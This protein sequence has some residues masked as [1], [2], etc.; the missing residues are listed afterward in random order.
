MT[1]CRLLSRFCLALT[2]ILTGQGSM[3]RDSLDMQ[4]GVVI[5]GDANLGLASFAPE[6]SEPR[7]ALDLD[8]AADD[9]RIDSL[10]PAVQG[11]ISLSRT[12]ITDAQGRHILL[13]SLANH[14]RT[15]AIVRLR[16]TSFLPGDRA[17]RL[18]SGTGWQSARGWR[19]E[20]RLAGRL[21][22]G[23]PAGVSTYP[24]HDP[25]YIGWE[26][27]LTLKP[28]E[29]KA[30]LAVITPPGTIGAADLGWLSAAQRAALIGWPGGKGGRPLL[31]GPPAR[32]AKWKER[33]R[34]WGAEALLEDS[35][36]QAAWLAVRF[37][38][39]APV[40][41]RNPAA[42]SE[43]R[44]IS[45]LDP[46]PLAGLPVLVKDIIDVVD[47]PTL[48]LATPM[49]RTERN[50]AAIVTRLRDAGAVIL[51]KATFDEDF[52]DYGLH[53]ATGRLRG[54]FHPDVTVTGSSG[55]SAV[56]V[57]AG[58]VPLA[59]GSDTCGSLGTPASHA[60]V[61]TLRPSVDALP[62]LGARPLNPDFDTLGP[63]LADATDLPQ[64]LT[65]LSAK[66]AVPGPPLQL[67]GLRLGVIE[68]W[69][70]DIPAADQ[71]VARQFDRAIARLRAAGV[72]LVPVALPDW[73]DARNALRAKPEPMRT[74]RAVEAWLAVRSDQRTIAELALAPYLLDED[75]AG[76]AALMLARPDP[77][78][79][80]ARD[81]ALQAVQ[82]A[83]TGPM[84]TQ[85][86]TALILPAT[87]AW[88][89]LLD[90]T[91]AGVGEP[92]MCPLSALARLPQA[93]IPLARQSGEPPL[94]AALLGLPG[95]DAM[96]GALAA[97]LAPI[98]ADGGPVRPLVPPSR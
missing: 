41:S 77:A 5:A 46:R 49:P 91:R 66:L 56:A 2:L 50:D 19:L 27:R 73:P 28:G 89:G 85:H 62:Y 71:A 65:A 78:A 21:V 12:R 38:G 96:L 14:G 9:H 25:G 76:M 63:V 94:G 74:A 16:W 87:L 45:P 58:I 26:L 17:S 40:S 64:A 82:H 95:E 61:A 6:G 86:V 75:R 42:F 39:L 51:G 44:A 67:K 18:A 84:A 57:A 43:A 7:P 72:Q 48:T 1:R 3:A 79:S 92:A 13:D 53:R 98:L 55:G 11:D 69:P 29:R 8:L 47:M 33:R 90:V 36:A 68:P 81:A 80:R 97:Q 35:L 83:L 10:R 23:W 20:T 32:L 34:Q 59:I 93:T 88:P 24:G 22:N 31:S 60:G 15:A 52:G 37:P 4:S 54:L 70:A 30:L